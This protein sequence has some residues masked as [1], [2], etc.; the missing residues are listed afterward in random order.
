MNELEFETEDARHCYW[1]SEALVRA[2]RAGAEN[3]VPVGA[4]VVLNDE[5]IGEGYNQPIGTHDPSAHAEMIALRQAADRIGNYRLV[6]ADLYVTIE[7]CTMCAGAM[8]HARVR[9]LIYGAPEPKAGVAKSN[10]CLFEQP[11]MNHDVEVLSGVMEQECSE[12]ISAFFARRRAEKKAERKAAK[13][14][15]AAEAEKPKDDNA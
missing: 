8:V 10:G 1:M 5:I 13:A 6:E 2:E 7:P 12:I 9:R 15:A 4:I 14:A 3:E 11:W